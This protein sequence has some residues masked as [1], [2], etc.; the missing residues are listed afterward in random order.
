MVYS[1]GN[2]EQ[3]DTGNRL[4]GSLCAAVAVLGLA[5]YVVSFSSATD[6]IGW[7]VRFA[8]LAALAAA[9][10]LLSR[11]KPVP[12]M[13]AV[14]AAMGFL[15]GLASVVSA[16]ANWASTVIVVLGG[17]QAVVA[18]VALRLAPK[19]VDGSAAGGYETYL[20]SYNQ[21]VQQYYRQQHA[22]VPNASQHSGYGQ[23]RG[24]AYGQAYGQARYGAQAPPQAAQAAPRQAQQAPQYGDYAELLSPQQDYGRNVVSPPPDPG[25]AVPPP[26]RAGAGPAQPGG[27]HVPRST[28]ESA[29]PG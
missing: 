25:A 8:A 13:I 4:P 26:G 22:A 5:V 21:A 2:S 15:D 1:P 14:L 18:I 6:A 17:V 23:A 24:E 20:D 11:Q 27:T 10:G 28:D 16:P 29:R 12:L 9:L 7:Q 19:A 3:R